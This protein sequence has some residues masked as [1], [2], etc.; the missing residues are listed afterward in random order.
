MKAVAEGTTHA[1]SK[2]AKGRTY[3][4]EKRLHL[5]SWA[6]QSNKRAI[7]NTRSASVLLAQMLGGRVALYQSKAGPLQGPAKNEVPE[8]AEEPFTRETQMT[9]AHLQRFARM[10][11][12]AIIQFV[13][14]HNF[15][16]PATQIGTSTQLT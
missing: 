8:T 9:H 1:A 15:A 16:V 2:C 3:L 5:G 6:C 14:W 13:V 11:Q 4:Q 7:D 10:R 12:V